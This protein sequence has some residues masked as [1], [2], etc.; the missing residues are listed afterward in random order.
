MVPNFVDKKSFSLYSSK[1]F[2]YI[3]GINVSSKF[4]EGGNMELSIG[5]Y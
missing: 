2:P 1:G 3:Q 4:I 5:T